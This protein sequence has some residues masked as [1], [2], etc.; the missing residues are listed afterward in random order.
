MLD[1][2]LRN[3]RSRIAINAVQ[4]LDEQ[5]VLAGADKSLD[6]QVLLDRLEKRSRSAICPYRWP[7]RSL[8]ELQVVGEKDDSSVVLLIQNLDAAQTVWAGFFSIVPGKLDYLVLDNVSVLRYSAF[9]NYPVC[10]VYL[11]GGL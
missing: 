9:S 10:G 3:F 6:L 7:P 4:N 1:R 11:S 5:R 8:L 2:N